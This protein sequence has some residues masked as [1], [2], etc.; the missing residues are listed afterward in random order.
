MPTTSPVL[1]I[2]SVLQKT[3]VFLR[4]DATL[5]IAFL[6]NLFLYHTFYRDRDHHYLSTLFQKDKYGI[7][8][9]YCLLSALALSTFNRVGSLDAHFHPQKFD[10]VREALMANEIFTVLKCLIVNSIFMLN[11]SDD[12]QQRKVH[13]WGVVIL[14][15][16]HVL[17]RFVHFGN[18]TNQH[19]GRKTLAA[20]LSGMG[21]IVF[22][23]FI[24]HWT[25][26]KMISITLEAIAL[27]C[28]IGH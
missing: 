20:V 28:T 22:S 16:S 2:A 6:G 26:S 15:V 5:H 17:H 11:T 8:I 3:S 12:S 27:S 25:H 10:M 23:R 19:F 24:P 7:V 14:V 21:F 1:K 4:T 9:S 13:M 18:V